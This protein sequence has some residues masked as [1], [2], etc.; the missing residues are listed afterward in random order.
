MS[1]QNP[2]CSPSN[3]S[4]CLIVHNLGSLGNISISFTEQSNK[5]ELNDYWT[6][7]L[8]SLILLNSIFFSFFTKS[9]VPHRYAVQI[10]SLCALK[11]F[12]YWGLYCG[13]D[14]KNSI[15]FCITLVSLKFLRCEGVT[16]YLIYLFQQCF[17]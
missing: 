12:K 4:Q 11:P 3:F 5:K 13:G 15:L 8:T 14:R 16:M 9:Q 1:L 17:Y 10:S 7:N 6:L 2:E